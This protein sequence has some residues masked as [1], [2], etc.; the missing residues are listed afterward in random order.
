MFEDSID[1]V[2]LD[3]LGD[4]ICELSAH[5]AAATYR[6][7]RL[8]AAFDRRGGWAGWGVKSCAHWLSWK[9]GLDLRTAREKLRVARTLDALPLICEEFARGALSYAKIR[10]LT[11]IATPQTEDA[12][13]V[14]ARHATAAH[15]E[16]LVRSYRRSV[17]ANEADADLRH[18]RRHLAYRYLEDGSIEIRARLDPEE[19]ALVVAAIEK[20]RDELRIRN[21]VSGNASDGSAEPR[22]DRADAL[23]E[24]SHRELAGAARRDARGDRYQ[25]MVHVDR[26]ALR[27]GEGICHLDDGPSLAPETARRLLC[28]GAFV[29]VITDGD[30]LDVGRKTRAIP[31]ALRRALAMRDGGCRFPGCTHTRFVDGHHVEHWADGG[32]T[33]LDNLILLCPFHHRLLHEGGFRITTEE[34]GRFTFLH[35]GGWVLETAALTV[36]PVPV[37]QLND[38]LRIGPRTITSRWTGERCDYGVGVEFLFKKDRIGTWGSAEPPEELDDVARDGSVPMSGCAP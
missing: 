31:S 27:T 11:R 12:L 30:K 4:R 1:D 32:R 15:V 23:V 5:I 26:E 36:E 9:C 19:G 10:A 25:V 6:W 28:D 34:D 17:P 20:V 22:H 8:L 35:K 21:R 3:E 14:F 7:L 2:P 38:G 29:P 24:I 13:I 18:E 33:S 37:E 16:K